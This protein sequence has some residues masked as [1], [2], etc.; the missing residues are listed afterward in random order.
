MLIQD[1]TATSYA[2]ALDALLSDKDTLQKLSTLSVQNAR[3][4]SWENVLNSVEDI[5]KQVK[6]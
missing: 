1:P 3:T 5:Y 4:Y 2:K 6:L